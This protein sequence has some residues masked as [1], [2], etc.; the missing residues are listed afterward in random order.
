MCLF[1]AV[2]QGRRGADVQGCRAGPSAPPMRRRIPD[3]AFGFDPRGIGREADI[4]EESVIQP[5]KREPLA[6]KA[7]ARQKPGRKVTQEGK[8]A[9]RGG[10][11]DGAEHGSVFH[12]EW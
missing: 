7:E 6:A 9:G 3:G 4:G 1:S 11:G 8:P 5:G 2:A 12:A 10:R